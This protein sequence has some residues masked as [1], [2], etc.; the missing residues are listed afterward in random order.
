MFRPRVGS[1]PSSSHS[2][3]PAPQPPSGR[4]FKHR[5]VI[6]SGK[7][8][9]EAKA[10]SGLGGILLSLNDVTPHRY[11]YDILFYNCATRCWAGEC[12]EACMTLLR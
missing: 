9:H 1:D 5:R 12:P 2:I 4:H 11:D 8:A 3:P 10:H 7:D 6:E